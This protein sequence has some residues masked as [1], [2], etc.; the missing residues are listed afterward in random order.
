VLVLLSESCAVSSIHPRKR[1]KW[2]AHQDL[3]LEPKRY[4]RSALTN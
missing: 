3:N 4:E 2:W 1:E